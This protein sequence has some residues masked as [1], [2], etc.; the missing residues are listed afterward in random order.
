[1]LWCGPKKTKK[2]KMEK[3]KEIISLFGQYYV[4]SEIVVSYVEIDAHVMAWT[5]FFQTSINSSIFWFIFNIFNLH[6]TLIYTIEGLDLFICSQSR[7]KL[8]LE[9]NIWI[10]KIYWN[11]ICI[12]YCHK[13]INIISWFLITKIIYLSVNYAYI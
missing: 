5:N 2:K 10:K 1:M 4:S 8:F 11:K 12:V 7:I 13:K 6:D 9:S 3:L